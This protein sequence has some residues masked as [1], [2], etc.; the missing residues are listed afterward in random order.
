MKISFSKNI[1]VYIFSGLLICF[2]TTVGFVYSQFK[3]L[4]D[5]KVVVEEKI[6]KLTG[7]NISIGGAEFKFEKGIS[8]RLQ[9]LSIDSLNGEDHEFLAKSAWC[10]VKLWPLLNKEIEIKKFIVEGVSIKLVR[11]KQGKFNFGNSL[12]WLQD[13]IQGGLFKVLGASFAHRLSVSDS[14]GRFLDYYNI[15]G[16]IRFLS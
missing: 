5:V 4:G 15:P 14:E 1:A 3:A 13:P 7:R 6:E 9:Q 10:V 8:I 16:P 12:R 2:L 11:D